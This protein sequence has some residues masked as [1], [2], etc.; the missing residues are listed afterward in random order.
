M[1]RRLLGN[2]AISLAGQVITWTSTLLLT[3]AYG[4]FLGAAKYG[5]LYFAL[6]FVML[7]AL[8]AGTSS[9]YDVQLTRGISED[10]RADARYCA[11]VLVIKT[12]SWIVTYVLALL[13]SFTFGFSTETRVLVGICGL[14]QLTGTITTTLGAIHYVNEHALYPAV[15]SIIE[16]G[17]STV[18]G[19]IVLFAG[20][21][22]W[23][24]AIV[25]LIGSLLNG[26]WQGI[27]AWRFI[28]G[29]FVID[30]ALIRALLRAN[31]P[32]LLY[33]LIG[34]LYFR[35]DVVLLSVM[36]TN[37]VVGWYGAGYQLFD[38]L[39]FIPGLMFTLLYPVFS[40]LALADDEGL[41]LATE[42][43]TNFALLTSMPIATALIV[44]APSI[45]GFLYRRPEFAH[46]IPSLQALAPGLVFL[47][48]N[49]ALGIAFL[50]TKQDY[51]ITAQ[52]ILALA[53]NVGLNLV[54]IPRLEHVGA[55]I[56]TSLTEVLIF[57]TEIIILP[58]FLRPR[59][60]ITTAGRAFAAS[61]I[62][63]LVM[64]QL[65]ALGILVLPIGAVV[66]VL[67]VLWTGAI[68]RGDLEM[69]RAALVAKAASENVESVLA[70]T[71]TPQNLTDDV[72]HTVETA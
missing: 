59:Q 17:T 30:R 20:G 14:I 35:L 34:T 37:T 3:L 66:Y 31:L 56:T 47:Y 13:V 33:G 70:A 11:N 51:K 60:S 50:N 54:L 45:I 55:A 19:V 27:W 8:P 68:D 2:V 16:K 43:L 48:L 41:R 40:K 28:R 58:Q 52:A 24:M 25:L 44:A 32:L 49:M 36:T 15:G 46:G 7:F 61:V 23:G 9:G 65:S 10:P 22:V 29:A 69:V 5:E 21:G 26:L 38:T 57:G 71:S 4:Y 53:F 62:M 6:T 1:L 42:K 12:F 18:L 63:G 67:L 72:L 64:A 39:C